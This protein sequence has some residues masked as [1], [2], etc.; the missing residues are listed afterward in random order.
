M[1][2]VLDYVCKTVGPWEKWPHYIL[3]WLFCNDMDSRIGRLIVCAFF[4]GHGIEAGML[5][6][7]I[8]LVNGYWDMYM[9]YSIH[10]WYN[11]WDSSEN[12]RSK[13]TYYNVR[14]GL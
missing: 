5:C 10:D 14:R 1:S 11:R 2:A 12:E 8:R 4:Y 7:L 3:E 6:R 9:K 13:R